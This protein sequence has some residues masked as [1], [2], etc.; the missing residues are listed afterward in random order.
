MTTNQLEDGADV[1]K[2]LAKLPK[3][4][5]NVLAVV[6]HLQSQLSDLDARLTAIEEA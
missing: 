2:A 6:R 3:I 5:D 1:D 4:D